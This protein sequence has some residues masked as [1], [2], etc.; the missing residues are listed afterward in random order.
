MPHPRNYRHIHLSVLP[1]DE[2]PSLALQSFHR[3]H[4]RYYVSVHPENLDEYVEPLTHA[5][6]RNVHRDTGFRPFELV[7][8]LLLPELMFHYDE[9]AP[10]PTGKDGTD[11]AY[12]LQ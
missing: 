9:N 4:V 10:P 11:F 2:Q 1:T 7:L 8:S 3:F 5:Y 12:Q 6:N